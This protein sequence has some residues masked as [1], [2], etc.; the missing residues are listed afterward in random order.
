MKENEKTFIEENDEIVTLN[1]D[2]GGT[3]D[4]YNLAELDFEGKWYIYLTPVTPDEDFAED[5]VIVYEMAENDDGEEVFLPVEDEDMLN[6]LI[7]LLNV[8]ASKE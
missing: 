1:Y 6:K 5:E 8:E 2:D 7:D 4:F 3:E